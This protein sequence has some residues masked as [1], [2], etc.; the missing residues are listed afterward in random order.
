MGMVRHLGECGLENIQPIIFEKVHPT[1]PFIRK[2]REQL[3]IDLL[4]AEINAQ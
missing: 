1:D 4:E 2:T 3:Y